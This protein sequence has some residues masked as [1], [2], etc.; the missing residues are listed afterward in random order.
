METAMHVELFDENSLPGRERLAELATEARGKGLDCFF[1]P[2]RPDHVTET[3][4]QVKMIEGL[5]P[6]L[7]EG[8]V[9]TPHWDKVG[10]EWYGHVK[11]AC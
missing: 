1:L 4:R 5:A 3:V 11:I 8:C 7:P 6:V 2:V 10:E 9:A